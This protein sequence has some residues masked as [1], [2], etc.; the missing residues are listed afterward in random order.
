MIASL[1]RL[2]AGLALSAMAACLLAGALTAAAPEVVC[3]VTHAQPF[4]QPVP[5][6]SEKETGIRV[7]AVYD[8]EASKTVGLVNR[9]L[10]EKASPLCDVFWNNEPARMLQLSGKGVLAPLETP[11]SAAIPAAFRDPGNRWFG[12]GARLRVLVY[13][14]DLV[15]ARD[16][17]RSVLDLAAPRWKGR[18]AI[19]N[20]LFGSTSTH[21]AALAVRLGEPK[22]RAF[23]EALRANDAQVVAGNAVVREVVSAGTASIGVTDTDDALEAIRSGKPVAMVVPD[24]GPGGLGALML[25][26]TVAVIEGAPHPDQARRLAEYLMGDSV[27]A[28]LAA[29][30]A[31]QIPLKPGLKPPPWLS[32]GKL[33]VP[34]A[35]DLEAAAA[36]IPLTARMVQDLLVR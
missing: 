33:P 24:Q 14:T 30:D 17:P 7:T 5:D 3:Y 21:V 11:A 22:L 1:R 28:Q 2:P 32:A 26:N 16:A 13:N 19:A 31:G 8:T 15:K 10:A 23:L 25:P 34:M 29:G 27:E 9:L 4:S 36:R 20:P 6:R 35:V 18:A 12:F